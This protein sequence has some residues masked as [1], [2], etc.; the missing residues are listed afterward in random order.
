[1]TTPII[2]NDEAVAITLETN[3]KY[4]IYMRFLFECEICNKKENIH[5]KENHEYL[6]SPKVKLYCR[7]FIEQPHEQS[8][9]S[10]HRKIIHTLNFEA[11]N[12]K[13][14]V[15]ILD[16]IKRFKENKDIGKILIFN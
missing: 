9:K 1:M 14:S 5:N 12:N 3:L 8:K 11:T 16:L 4:Y 6:S 2:I 7:E 15:S 10:I 13:K